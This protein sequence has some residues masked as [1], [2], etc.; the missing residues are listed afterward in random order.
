MQHRF[1]FIEVVTTDGVLVAHFSANET[2]PIARLHLLI[3]RT[4]R[5]EQGAA[6]RLPLCGSLCFE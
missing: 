2:M 1:T 5:R 4:R 3:F 6:P